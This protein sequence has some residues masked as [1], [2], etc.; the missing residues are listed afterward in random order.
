M[1][2]AHSS[3]FDS[4]FR[5]AMRGNAQIIRKDGKAVVMMRM[6]QWVELRRRAGMSEGKAPDL[7]ENVDD[8][9]DGASCG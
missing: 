1:T 9:E 2:E 7:N 6:D 3:D 5:D 8:D 4:A